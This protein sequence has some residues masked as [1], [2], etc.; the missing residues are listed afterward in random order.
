VTGRVAGLGL[1]D[2]PPRR[3]LVAG[4]PHRDEVSAVDDVGA[5][6]ALRALDQL[7]DL[8]EVGV[9]ELWSCQTGE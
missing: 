4:E 5:D 7:F 2:G 9:D 8:F 6:L 3:A 1:S